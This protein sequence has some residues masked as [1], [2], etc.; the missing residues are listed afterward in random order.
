MPSAIRRVQRDRVHHRRQRLD[1]RA[2][3]ERARHH[4]SRAG[5]RG[6]AD[7]GGHIDRLRHAPRLLGWRTPAS[8]AS[9][10]RRRGRTAWIRRSR[11]PTDRRSA[12]RGSPSSRT[13]TSAR[14]RASATATA[15]GKP[16]AA[17]CC[18]STRA[19]IANAHAVAD[20][21]RPHDLMPRIVALEEDGLPALPPGAG[22]PRRLN[23]TPDVIQSHGLDLRTALGIAR[24]R[25]RLGRPR[26]GRPDRASRIAVDYEPT[27]DDRPGH[28]SRHHGQ[29]QPAVDA[30][31]RHA[32]RQ[33]RRR[34]R[35]AHVAILDSTTSSSGAARPGA[36]ASRWRRRCRCASPTTGTS[37]SFVVTAE[38]DGDVAYVAS[39]WNEGITP[40]EFGSSFQSVGSDGHPARIGLH[41]SRRLQARRRGARQGHR[42]RRHADRHSAAAR[43][44]DARRPRARQPRTAKSTGAR[45]RSTAG[46]APSGRGPCRPT[47]RSATTR[48]SARLPGI[49]KAGGQRRAPQRVRDG[50]WLKQVDGIVSRRGVPAAGLS[51]RHDAHG[52]H[53]CR[54]RAAARHASTRGISSAARW[55]SGRCNGPSRASRTSRCRRPITENFPGDTYAFGY[56]PRSESRA[57]A[58]VAG[59]RGDARRER[60]ARR[61]RAARRATSTSRT[62]T[63]SKATSRTSRASTSPTARASSCIPRRGTSACD[64]PTTSRTSATGTSVDVVAVDLQGH[65][66]PDVPV[67]LSLVHIQWNSVRHARRRRLLHVGNRT[68]RD[69]GG[70]VDGDVR[71]D[72][73]ARS[74][75]P[76]PK[77]ATTSCTRPRRTPRDTRRARTRTSTASARATPRGSDSITTASRSSRRRRRGSPATTARVMIQSP[78]ETATALL[79][80]EREGVRR[81]ERFDADVDAADRRGADHRG[82][83]FPNVYVSVLLIRGRTSNDPGA[84]GSD[85]GKPA[86]RLGYTELQR[87]GRDEAPRR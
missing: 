16:T 80:V 13:G 71:G 48:S 7:L 29:G 57:D 55:R 73:A 15:S 19:T 14:S 18:P 11:P 46:A 86:F 33:R 22:T 65:A 41:R 79:T 6:R 30:R 58:R 83:T 44:V 69:A 1:V 62:A 37:F 76:C 87:R 78:W 36:T 20:A 24:V 59:A 34:C 81:Y 50:D 42:P 35:S 63:R 23:V 56:Y 85:P 75:F 60:Q 9:R 38:K 67:T 27:V 3:V 43:R 72:A 51:R 8:I 17:R 70:R 53:A 82:R 45:S 68:G 49:G 21:A 4:G 64:G 26:A 5:A 77:A 25:A 66:V 28:Q 74:G 47:A 10:R 84:D 39:N 61:R 52:R 32:A 54:R 2:R 12:T 31:L 40:W